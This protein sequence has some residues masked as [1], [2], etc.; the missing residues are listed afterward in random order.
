MDDQSARNLA[1]IEKYQ[2]DLYSTLPEI[3]CDMVMKG[4]ITSGV[5]YPLAVCELARRHR[6]VSLGGSSAGGIAAAFAAAAEYQRITATESPRA[7]D[8]P[9]E[10]FRRLA[11]L[12]VKLGDDL[13]RLFQPSAGTRPAFDAFTAMSDKDASTVARVGRA[14][15]ALLRGQRLVVLATAAAVLLV[16]L[17]S[18]MIPAGAPRT[19]SDWAWLAAALVPALLVAGPIAAVAGVCRGAWHALRQVAANGY[20]LCIGS[21]GAVGPADGTQPF[22]DWMNVELNHV[23]GRDGDPPLTFGDLWGLDPA[24]PQVRLEMMTT[25]V[26]LCRPV[27]L[28]LHTDGYLYCATELARWFPQDVLAALAVRKVVATDG[29]CP[30]HGVPL[31]R[32]P[33]PAAFPVVVAVRL[34]LSFPALI[35]PVPLFYRDHSSGVAE[36]VRCH[37]SDGGISSNFPMHFFD[38]LWPSRPTFGIS[39]APFHPAHEGRVYLPSPTTTRT[40]RVR[41]TSTLGGFAGAILDTLQNWSDEALSALPAYSTRIAEVH[42]HPDEGGLNLAMTRETVY[43]LAAAGAEAGRCLGTFDFEDHRWKRYLTAMAKLQHSVGLMRDRY[44][45]VTPTMK[46]GYRDLV[47]AREGTDTWRKGFRWWTDQLMTFAGRPNNEP[48]TSG[49]HDF[50]TVASRAATDLRITPRL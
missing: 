42:L 39:L 48:Q 18:A 17:W 38:E 9:G 45:T 28:P 27:R 37:F 24:K 41:D 11:H 25:N 12:P 23:A 50:D 8:V 15:R 16:F 14:M 29:T 2:G 36:L 4:G 40:P 19:A 5:V 46:P 34:T 30:D 33:A 21:A 47:D 6:L 43:G 3:E 20:G 7:G 13:P 49:A 31:R 10:G 32:L 26:T 22:I 44:E 1:I 35:S